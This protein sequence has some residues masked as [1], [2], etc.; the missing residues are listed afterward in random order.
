NRARGYTDD[1]NPREAPEWTALRPSGAFLSTVL[2]LAKGDV[3]LDT[4]KVLTAATRQQMWTPV[5]L[6]EGSTHPYG[7][8]WGLEPLKGHKRIR[9]GGSPPRVTPGYRRFP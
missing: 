9:H 7:F 3:L 6:N 8:G 4:D 5:T 1:D 2:A